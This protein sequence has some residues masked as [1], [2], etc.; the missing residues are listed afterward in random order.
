M[1]TYKYVCC[2]DTDH[3]PPCVLYYRWLSEV[4]DED[5]LQQTDCQQT[6]LVDDEQDVVHLVLEWLHEDQICA[7]LQPLHP[8]TYQQRKYDEAVALRLWVVSHEDQEDYE[9]KTSD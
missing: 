1:S 6:A 2:A 9:H 7:R 3:S 5:D 8:S 4:S